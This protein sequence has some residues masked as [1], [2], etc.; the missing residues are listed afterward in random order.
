MSYLKFRADY[1]HSGKEW[2]GSDAVLI[3]NQAGRIENIVNASEAG[4]G[5]RTLDGMISPGFINCHCHLE[6]SHLKGLIPEKTGLVDFV[7]RIITQRQFNPEIIGDAIAG[8]EDEMLE[9]G[10]VAV[11]DICNGMDTISQKQRQRLTYYNFIEVSGW[12][13][14]VAPAR[15]E[16]SKEFYDLY[17]Q[18]AADNNQVSLAPHAPYSVSN[19]L[20]QL[21]Q[22]FFRKKTTTIHNQET[23]AED[24][25]FR[26]GK[27]DLLRMYAMMNIDTRFFKPTG[28][29]SLQSCLHKLD[30]AAHVLF[31]HDTFSNQEDVEYLMGEWPQHGGKFPKPFFCICANANLFIEDSMPPLELIRKHHGEIVL[32]TDSLASNHSLD[33][34]EEIRTIQKHF[35]ALSLEE[36]LRSATF[37]GAKAL[38]LDHI[39][40]SFEPGKKPGIVLIQH[41][42]QGTLTGRSFVKMIQLNRNPT[43]RQ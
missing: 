26:T 22:P 35:P 6:L 4:E 1:L 3:T 33:I 37:N 10:I 30:E 36:M 16:K 20:W 21:I 43:H 39:F 23:A 34:L 32:G 12:Q 40:G 5:V 7:F 15:F 17:G 38:Q 19:E 18:L 27:G 28:K 13:P 8:A 31:V 29:S 41:H 2:L 42:D 11:G 24:E 14:T 9:N 25:L